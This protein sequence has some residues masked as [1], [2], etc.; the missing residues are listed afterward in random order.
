MD[1]TPLLDRAVRRLAS[2]CPRR[3]LAALL[4]AEQSLSLALGLALA[5]ARQQADPVHALFLRVQTLE[6]RLAALREENDILRQ[7]LARER[8]R[9]RRHYSPPLRFRIVRLLR[10]E[11]LSL[12]EAAGRFLVSPQTIARWLREATA[13]PE[14]D[15]VG[16]LIQPVP[17]LRRY[18]DV[19][20]HLVQHL[21]SL[22]LGGKDT[23]AATLAR[24][25]WSLSPR[26]VGRIRKEAPVLPPRPEPPPVP[27]GRVVSARYPNHV[28]MA[29][30]TEIPGPFRLFS[31][32]LAAVLDVFSRFPLAVEV[33][34]AEPTTEDLAN[35]V[36]RAAAIHGRPRHF[37]S[38]QGTQF[39]ALAFRE[40][41]RRL[42]TR[43]RFGAV[44]K[45]GSIAIIERLWLTL[46]SLLGLAAWHPLSAVD[47][48]ERLGPV[49]VYYAYVRPHQGLG[50]AVPAERYYRIPAATGSAGPSPRGRPGEGPL[51]VPVDVAYLDPTRGRLPFLVPRAA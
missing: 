12:T 26:S 8:P 7:R 45:T 36:E 47:L 5:R 16:S 4:Q 10:S 33:F 24:A 42:G 2:D 46:K 49:L 15:T 20:R 31:L 32:R 35:L 41:L 38:D 19:V 37:V 44:G 17:P 28:W 48:R 40:S 6:A 1:E 25:A 14:R 22:G 29:D 9:R 18:A 30:L 34:Q 27:L 21:D 13:H 50:G 51:D 23:I 11:V 3:A 43:Q 39:T